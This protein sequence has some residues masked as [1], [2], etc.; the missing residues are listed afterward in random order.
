MPGRA[1]RSL[2][3]ESR[4]PA[5]LGPTPE[6]YPLA[7]PIALSISLST[8]SLSVALSI[9]LSISLSMSLS[10]SLLAG[11]AHAEAATAG[12]AA[13]GSNA[14]TSSAIP[15]TMVL[16]PATLPYPVTEKRAACSD[17]EP[18]RRP[19]FGD[20]HV[21]TARSQD[22]STQ[23]TRVTPREA[24]RFATGAPL[25]I[26]PFDSAGKSLRTVKLDRPLDFAAV[27]DHAEQIGEVHICR[28]PGQPGHDSLVC[29]LYRNFPRVAFFIMNGR[30]SLFESR[31]GFCGKNAENCLAAAGTVW[32][33]HQAAAEAAYD[34]EASCRFTSFVAY[35]WTASGHNG[36]HLHRNVIFRNEMVPAL[37]TSV[38]ETG[39]M[40]IGLWQ[41]LDAECRDGKPGCESITIP[42][43]SNWSDGSQFTSAVTPGGEITKEEAAIRARYER[44][45]EVMQH[46]GESECAMTPGVTDE[47][48]GFEKAPDHQNP[49]APEKPQAVDFVRNALERGLVLAPSLAANPFQFGLIGSTDTHLGTPGLVK[50]R[51]FSGHGGAGKPGDRALEPGLPDVAALNPGGLAVLWAE[52]NSRDALFEAMLR[53]EAYATSGTRPTLRFFGGW[54]YADDSCSGPNVARAGYAQGVPMGGELPARPSRATAPRFIVS[55]VRDAHQNGGDLERIEIVKGWSENGVAKEK[56]LTVAGGDRKA[57]VDL[58]TCEPRGRGHTQLCTVWADPDFDPAAPAF[59][60]ARLRENPSCRWTQWACNAAGVRCEDP[61]TITEGYEPCCSGEVPPTIQERA[62][63]SPIWY[64]P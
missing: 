47:G 21:H 63:S 34:R 57:D 55:A 8:I 2:G 51:G 53:K 30:Y 26:Q 22:A 28:T 37:P 44:L 16:R 50:E 29:G 48:C 23:D 41:R 64:R 59:Y 12:P 9:S 3:H 36:G 43:N 32:S 49:R 39:S 6:T 62:W 18:E 4:L 1:S 20:L 42:H 35:E 54:D 13:S 46:K 7:R 25:G 24:Y 56:V 58:A 19:F 61:M 11:S 40:A 38:M 5:P 45:V 27:T 52:E 31:W 17:Y 33:E 15:D 14:T 10:I 60:Y